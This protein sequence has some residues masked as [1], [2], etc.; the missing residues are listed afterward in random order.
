MSK[1][2]SGLKKTFRELL[3]PTNPLFPT[4]IHPV[5]ESQTFNWPGI[6]RASPHPVQS[7]AR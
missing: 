2:K 7:P 5:T 6:P 3:T 1:Q 4:T